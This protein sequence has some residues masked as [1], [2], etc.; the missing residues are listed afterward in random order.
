MGVA[1]AWKAKGKELL[2]TAETKAKELKRSVEQKAKGVKAAVETKRKKA[3]PAEEKAAAEVESPVTPG[4][5][6]TS[7]D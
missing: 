7:M 1:A 3:K 4:P 5:D 6:E 2:E